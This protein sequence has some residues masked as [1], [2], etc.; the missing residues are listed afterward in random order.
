VPYVPI[1]DISRDPDAVGAELDEVCRTVGF[2]Q[3]TGHGLADGVAQFVVFAARD[4][5]DVVARRGDSSRDGE[6]YTAAASG[7]Q[8]VMHRAGPAFRPR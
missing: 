4:R 5:N 7:D 6:A 1:I 8:N 2:F 3:I